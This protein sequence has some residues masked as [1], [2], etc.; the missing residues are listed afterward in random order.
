[1]LAAL[2]AYDWPGNVRELQNVIERAVI[3][4]A[5][6]H[7]AEHDIQLSPLGMLDLS[8]QSGSSSGDFREISLGQ[9]EQE[10]I[11]A[12]LERTGWNKS[13]AAQLLG[14]ERS[15]LDRKLKRYRVSRPKP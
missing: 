2:R 4:C 9:L 13:R 10:H 14:I 3:L 15:T 12:T 1:A 7:I 6:E 11:L 5:N 8:V